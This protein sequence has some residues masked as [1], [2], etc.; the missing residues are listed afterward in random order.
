MRCP[1]CRRH[2]WFTAEG[3]ADHVDR[4]HKALVKACDGKKIRYRTSADA[5]DALI[6]ANRKPREKRREHRRYECAA[7]GG[8]HLTS[9]RLAT[10]TGL[11][12]TG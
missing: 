6:S 7:C 10:T 4:D 12:A 9:R 2:A 11:G 1:I 5:L 8:W 3:V